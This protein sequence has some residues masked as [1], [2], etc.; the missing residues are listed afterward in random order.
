MVKK[1]TTLEEVGGLLH[2]HIAENKKLHYEHRENFKSIGAHLVHIEEKLDQLARI[3]ELDRRLE[4]LREN[5]REK[6]HIEV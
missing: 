6:L 1:I 3:N 4:R 5:I 2:T